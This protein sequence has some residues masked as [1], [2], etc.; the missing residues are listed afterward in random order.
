MPIQKLRSY[1][2]A[3][4]AE[5]EKKEKLDIKIQQSRLF[6]RRYARLM[7]FLFIIIIFKGILLDQTRNYKKTV[8]HISLVFVFI[9]S[10]KLHQA[11]ESGAKVVP[12]ILGI[13]NNYSHLEYLTTY[14]RILSEH[15]DGQP[16]THPFDINDMFKLLIM[17]G[18]F[19]ANHIYVDTFLTL[20]VYDSMLL[21]IV[22]WG[23]F[24]YKAIINPGKILA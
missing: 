16:A 14:T 3:K 9:L 24:S 17:F 8:Y 13:L 10:M 23:F 4:S 19:I 20:S 15:S 18:A 7:I 6:A 22:T 21:N 2:N 11:Y 5:E 12:I 1:F